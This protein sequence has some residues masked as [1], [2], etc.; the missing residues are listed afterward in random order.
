MKNWRDISYRL[1]CQQVRKLLEAYSQG[2]LAMDRTHAVAGH[3]SGCA[4]CQEEYETLFAVRCVLNSYPR[5]QASSDFNLRV[6]N[7]VSAASLLA[8]A[9]SSSSQGRNWWG[10]GV[11]FYAQPAFR[12]AGSAVLGVSL[13]LVMGISM[14]FPSVW[15][16]LHAMYTRS[17]VAN[18][19]GQ[20]PVI[21]ELGIYNK[22]DTSR[23]LTGKE[24]AP[25]DAEP[26]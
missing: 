4:G 9:N 25:D 1:S 17:I 7:Q 6:L 5:I 23:A 2:D 13:G 12:L 11:R 8:G 20:A 24:N 16:N 22:V 21:R 14:F 19:P 18:L 3:L 10:R 15:P 26:K